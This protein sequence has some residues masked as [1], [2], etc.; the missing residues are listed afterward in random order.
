MQDGS[1]QKVIRPAAKWAGISKLCSTHLLR[2]SRATHMLQSGYGIRTV[3]GLLLHSDVSTPLFY[4]HGMN[5]GWRAVR[6]P[7]DQ[8]EG[9]ACRLSDQDA[10]AV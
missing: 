8:T 1:V 7:F 9:R 10:A 6:S 2:D 5:R 4:A 3:P